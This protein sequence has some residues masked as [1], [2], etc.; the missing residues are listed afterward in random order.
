MIVFD[1][2]TQWSKGLLSFWA[3]RDRQRIHC[4][5]G[6]ETIAEL[7][8]FTH[9]TRREIGSRKAE[10]RDLLKPHFLRKIERNEFEEGLI[11]TVTMF[12]RDLERLQ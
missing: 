2:E 6:L 5:A 12:M 3:H 9:A 4:L 11:P 7:P 8:G 10:L 1:D